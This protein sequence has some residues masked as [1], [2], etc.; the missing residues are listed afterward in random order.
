MLSS[1]TRRILAWPS[2]VPFAPPP[3]LQGRRLC[4]CSKRPATPAPPN[5]RRLFAPPSSALL[6][7]R[8]PPTPP[9]LSLRLPALSFPLACPNYP[10]P[11]LISSLPHDRL[12]RSPEQPGFADKLQDALPKLD[13]SDLPSCTIQSHPPPLL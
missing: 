8:A 5:P 11:P 7:P 3:P 9:P 13:V 12:A 2:A 4:V 1:E 6:V 10:V